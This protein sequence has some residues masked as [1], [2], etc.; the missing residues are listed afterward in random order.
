MSLL[1]YLKKKKALSPD[2]VG[3]GEQLTAGSIQDPILACSG[4]TKIL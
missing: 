2:T 1:K 3:E 4:N